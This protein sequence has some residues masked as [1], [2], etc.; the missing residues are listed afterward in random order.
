MSMI[1]MPN[2]IP[3]LEGDIEQL[4]Q[5]NDDTTV[6]SVYLAT[7]QP[8]YWFCQERLP[9]LLRGHA[10]MHAMGQDHGD[11]DHDSCIWQI[12]QVT[13]AMDQAQVRVWN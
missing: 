6:L 10:L 12:K 7:T 2:T 8:W 3:F 1:N 9:L 5:D 13:E 11:P 4:L